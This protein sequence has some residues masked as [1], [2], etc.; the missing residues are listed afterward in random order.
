MNRVFGYILAAVLL[1]GGVQAAYVEMAAPDRISVGEILMVEGSSLGTLN[2][3]FSTDLI[4]YQMLYTKKE[5]NRSQIVVQEGGVFSASFPT[6]GLPQGQYLLELVD[7]YPNGEEAFGGAAQKFHYVTLVDRSDEITI[8]SPRVQP[9]NGWLYLKGSLSSTGNNGTEI[10]V[11]KG[12][13][14]V[15]GP[16]YIATNNGDFMDTIAI[17]GGGTYKVS[18][19]DAKGYIGTA[20]FAVTEAATTAP[21]TTAARPDVVVVATSSRT[22]PAYFTVDSAGG[23]LRIR[24]SSGIDWILEYVDEAGNRYTLNQKGTVGGESVSIETRGG[25]VYVKVYPATYTDQG[26]VT[27]TAENADAASVCTTCASYFAE[28]PSPTPTQ[29]T[30][31]P[32]A[33]GLL[34]LLFLALRRR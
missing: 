3:G 7:P 21:V 5:V 22:A 15:F 13:E 14:V 11:S 28:T 24:T 12:S 33:I 8:T 6:E 16:E 18:F 1:I 30:P 10:R 23:T 32:A 25:P 4:F 27:L 20:E 2:P 26:S 19:S 17:T 34:S 29:E 9:Y 31:L